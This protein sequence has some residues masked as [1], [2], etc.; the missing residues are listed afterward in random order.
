MFEHLVKHWA[1]RHV[2]LTFL[3]VLRFC[4]EHRLMSIS[5][6]QICSKR[7][8]AFRPRLHVLQLVLVSDIKTLEQPNIYRCD[9]LLPYELLKSTVYFAQLI[10]TDHRLF[11]V[12]SVHYLYC[13][14][15]VAVTVA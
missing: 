4:Y 5:Y 10:Q 2:L 14:A 1:Y 6:L 15:A 9:W 7:L 12:Q 13:I 11:T 3:S 8:R